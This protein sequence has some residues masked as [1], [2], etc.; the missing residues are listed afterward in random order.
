MQ[1]FLPIL[2]LLATLRLYGQSIIWTTACTGQTFCLD[3]G[4]C[5][6]GTVFLVEKAVTSCGNKFINYSYK[7][8]LG[9]N[10]S[11][12][13][14]SSADTV[15][16]AFPPGTHQITWRAA[17]NCGNVSTGCSYLFT[18]KDC[19][20]PNLVCLN[21]L[22]QNLEF[23]ECEA[24]FYVKDFILNV[25]DNCT[26]A[27]QLEFGMR[28][29]GTGTGF[30]TDTTLSFGVCEQGLHVLEIWVRDKGKLAN[31]CNSYVLV[32][33][34]NG[35]CECNIDANIEL[36]GCART[37]DS[38]RLDHYTIRAKLDGQPLTGPPVSKNISKNTT[39]SCFSAVFSALPLNGSYSGSVRAQRTDDPLDGVSTFDLVLI[40]KHILGQQ[41]L[42]NFY[43][44]L[45]ADVNQSQ[46]ITTFDIIEIRKLILGI[47]DTFPHASSWRFIRPL[48]EPANLT[49]FAAVRD[50]YP[51][52]VLNLTGD[53]QLGNFHFIG[54]KM[55]DANSN[56]AFAGVVA[57]DRHLQPPLVLRAAD[58][59]LETGRSYWVPVRIPESAELE[60]WQLALQADPEALLIQDIQ[61]IPLPYAALLPT[62]ELRLSNVEEYPRTYAANEPLVWLQVLARQ[63]VL[64]SKALRI[65]ATQLR[66]EAYV[67]GGRT[68]RLMALEI[69]ETLPGVIFFP[70]QPNP[71]VEETRFGV[72]LDAVA[73]ICLEV[74]GLDG[75]RVYQNT[76]VL[77]AGS[78]TLRLPGSALPAAGVWAYRIQAGDTAASG[79]VVKW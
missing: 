6:Q 40:N 61:G 56:A 2:F 7:I 77:E 15:N 22:T 16:Q 19:N 47:Y 18:V 35:L 31:Q 34:N 71:F 43:Q 54:V 70:P 46:T 45:A 66:P 73:T 50:T 37:A 78:H 72:Q 13:I 51:F 49:G 52:S 59:Q 39:D 69:G 57:S 14:Q 30:P 65:N 8:D 53:T 58:I 33:D 44:V 36:S 64:L 41:P 17:D 26:P 28:V 21:G 68:P 11:I 12:D 42:E 27:N 10:G 63:P 38:A 5:T 24:S 20:P 62:G 60:G 29:I 76:Q 67:W 25:S 3:P 23:P 79:R 9:N 55:G 48:A 1:R 4:S 32:Q 74:F 75:R